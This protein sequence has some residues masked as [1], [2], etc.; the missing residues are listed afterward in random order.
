MSR[1]TQ[2]TGRTCHAVYG[3]GGEGGHMGAAQ[4]WILLLIYQCFLWIKLV[5]TPHTHV[6]SRVSGGN[7]IRNNTPR[8]DGAKEVMEVMKTNN[9]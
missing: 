3:G 5:N 4:Q 7:L 9:I 8:G 6:K 2:D 1:V